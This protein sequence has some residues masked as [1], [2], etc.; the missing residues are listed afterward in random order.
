MGGEHRGGD[1]TVSGCWDVLQTAANG[2]GVGAP[3]PRAKSMLN[4]SMLNQCKTHKTMIMIRGG[5][6]GR[7]VVGGRHCAARSAL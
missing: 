6:G 5:E 7:G 1:A 2:G 3:R 4:Q